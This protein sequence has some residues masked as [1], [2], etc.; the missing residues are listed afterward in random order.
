MSIKPLE[1]CFRRDLV[2]F[3]H[4]LNDIED[5][6]S[7]Y[8]LILALGQS[9]EYPTVIYEYCHDY[10][11]SDELLFMRTNM[12]SG[13]RK[14]E[15]LFDRK[16]K[17]IPGRLHARDNLT[18]GV[19][20][21]EFVEVYSEFPKFERKLKLAKMVSGLRS[22]FGIPLRTPNPRTRAGF[23]VASKLPREPFLE[24]LEKNGMLLAFAAWHTHMK[25]MQLQT[26]EQERPELTEN[27][28]TYLQLLC[29]GLLDKQISDK[30]GI[31]HSG[32][33]KYQLAISKKLGVTQRAQI[34]SEAL[35]L[36]YSSDGNMIANPEKNTGLWDMKIEV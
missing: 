17:V 1:A 27:Q 6:E 23:G 7:A 34:V 9:L 15:E 21:L 28:T 19:S 4:K 16:E 18:M 5:C 33:R 11:R 3:L 32:V 35:R 26:L 2:D 12:P 13:F 8:Q 30:M 10:T 25:I 29:D 22:G 20:G 14:M 24:N 31:S 36:G